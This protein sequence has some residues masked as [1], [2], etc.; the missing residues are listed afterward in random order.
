MRWAALALLPAAAGAQEPCAGLWEMVEGWGRAGLVAPVEADAVGPAEDGWC[1]AAGVRAALGGGGAVVPT[2]LADRLR[3]RG[4]GL[5]AV[6]AGTGL[7]TAIEVQ[8]DGLRQL[9]VTGEPVL[10]WAFEA[11]GRPHGIEARLAARWDREA[12]AVEVTALSLDLPGDNGLEATARIE[13]VDLS[14]PGAAATSAGSMA[15]ARLDAS[16]D[17]H[18]LFEDWLLLPLA[19]AVLAD[20]ADP[21][22]AWDAWRRS[23][24]DAVAAMPDAL[25]PGGT[26]AALKALL[27]ELPNP[28]GRLDLTLEAAEGGGLGAAR[29]ARFAL[30]GAPDSPAELWAALDGLRVA[31]TWTPTRGPDGG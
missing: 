31:A 1:E 7:P 11:Q 5:D 14:T 22:A 2:V 19:S 15:L 16:L 26:R 25:A 21:E 24:L 18:G 20:A 23:A 30:A 6:L 28:A 13:G 3:W 9:T 29:F 17:S 4:E 12:R 27:L 8:A 10:D